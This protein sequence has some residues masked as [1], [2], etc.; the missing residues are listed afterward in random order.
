MEII[1]SE[2]K[3]KCLSLMDEV[4]RTGE[5]VVITKHGK[6][7]A[8][9]MPVK[10]KKKPLFGAC[11]GMVKITGDIMAPVMPEW[12]PDEDEPHLYD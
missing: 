9:L 1:A 6:P 11:K 7:I 2:F 12:H 8:R 10:E 5:P 4:A 3:A